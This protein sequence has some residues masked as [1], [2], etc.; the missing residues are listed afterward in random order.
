[1]TEHSAR[2]FV[3]GFYDVRRGTGKTTNDDRSRY[4]LRSFVFSLKARKHHP[5]SF[6][7]SRRNNV[8]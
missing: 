6:D 4:G 7:G 8:Q 2:E 3:F 5:K 1:M